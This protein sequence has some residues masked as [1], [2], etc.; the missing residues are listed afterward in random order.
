MEGNLSQSQETAVLALMAKITSIVELSKLLDTVVK[1]L[2]NVVG[3][4]GCW[5]YLEPEYVSEYQQ[6]V[7]R[8][9]K[10]IH[11]SELPD[12][13]NDFI[14]LAATNRDTKKKL[15]GK[16]FFY[17]GEGV[18]G[19]VYKQGRALNIPDVTDN[20]ALKN[21]SPDLNWADLYQDGAEFYQSNDRRPLLIIPLAIG[22]ESIGVIKFHSSVEQNF[23]TEMSERIATIVAQIISGV[24]RQTWMVNEQSRAI[25]QI[26]EFGTKQQ[27]MDV[28]SSVTE[29]M[30]NMFSATKVQFFLLNEDG[31]RVVLTIQNGQIVPSS[32]RAAFPKGHSLIGWVFKTG[33]SLILPDIREFLHGRSINTGIL[34]QI[35]DGEEVDDED[36]F[37]HCQE[38]VNFFTDRLKTPVPFL[39][40]PVKKSNNDVWG[41]LAIYWTNPSKVKQP[42]DRTQL[43]L[44]QSFAGTISLALENNRQKE[45]A[46]LLTELGYLTEPKEL[47][48][49]VVNII[50]SLITSSGCS[51]FI[52]VSRDDNP[53]LRLLTTSRTHLLDNTG[54][55][56][57]IEYSL[58]QGK[59]GVCSITQSTI[60]VNHF[61]KGNVSQKKMTIELNRIKINHKNDI[62]EILKDQD[63]NSV[64]FI[65]LRG[66]KLLPLPIRLPFKELTKA[67]VFDR[68]GLSSPTMKRYVKNL[69][70]KSWSF[71]AVPIIG[72]KRLLG[73]I[74]LGRPVSQTPFSAADATLA[75][76]ISGRI[77]SVMTNLEL[78]DQRKRLMMSLAHEIH[79][80][81]T[82]ILASSESLSMELPKDSELQKIAN[83][84]M[85]QVLRLHLQTSTIMSVLSE[86]IP[87]RKFS[88]HSIYRPLKEACELFE[89]EAAHK[90]CDIY[91]PR[92]LAG[93]FP[94]IEMSLFDLTIAFKNIIHNAIK[95]S[96]R[97]PAGFDKQ[98][99]IK[100]L[101]SWDNDKQYYL[102]SVQNYGVGITQEEIDKRL[103]FQSF[104]R[105]LKSSDR[106]RTGA[107]F[108]LTHARQVI[109][110][111]HNGKIFVKSEPQGGEAY[112]TTFTVRMPITQLRL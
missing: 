7:I 26:I 25:A 68:S 32:Q 5:I 36:K 74:T 58:G 3:A 50:P 39:A 54:K 49:K 89:M 94:T 98:R 83:H 100:V 28:I 1:E 16:A 75:K 76:S 66:G 85:G 101:G 37:L 109:E 91:G 97:P 34:S 65:Q 86:T 102:V 111:M 30:K 18:A 87:E 38:P 92:T 93:N 95:Y 70:E 33:R 60:V 99:Y 46:S 10:E 8:D 17:S 13:T 69:S 40:V 35:S 64:G 78:Q 57:P 44:A 62:V 24:I 14:V 84:N 19:W 72:E 55:A 4:L 104:Y 27:P 43:H 103:I 12:S 53:R 41:I 20:V 63:G 45:L 59:T 47:F 61:G 15:V 56:I 29:S 105:G 81:L 11:E 107:G 82:G 110:D 31:S 112:L 90:R 88:S 80:P 6:I 9:D 77:G 23:F 96:F 79:T 2:P 52:L 67:T 73:V 108:G 48:N 21:I 106:R 22:D 51:V 71:I 42:F